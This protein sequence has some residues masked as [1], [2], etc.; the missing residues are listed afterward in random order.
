[1]HPFLARVRRWIVTLA[2]HAAAL[3]RRIRSHVVLGLAVGLLSPA[4]GAQPRP[5]A[6]PNV[7]SNPSAV[8][9][10]PLTGEP[11][12]LKTFTDP[13]FGTKL[14]RIA[15]NPGTSTSPVSGTWGS[16]TRHH[17]SKDQPWSADGAFYCLENRA[18]GSPSP[19]ILDGHTFAPLFS[20]PSSAGLWD[21]RWHPAQ[22]HAHELINVNSSGTELSWVD[23]QTGRKTRT[24]TLPFAV[25]GFGA[26][27]GNASVDGRYVALASGTRMFVVDM[28]PLPPLAPY[29]GKRI[30]PAVDVSSCGLSGG[31]S[32]DWVSISA[33]GKYAVVNY[34]G[35]HPRVFDIDPATLT[36]SPHPRRA[37]RRAAR[38]PPPA[39]T[40]TTSAMPISPESVRQQC[41]RTD[42]TGALRQPRRDLGGKKIGYVVMVRLSD[43]AITPLTSPDNEAYPHHVSTRNIRMP[44][45]A[46]VSHYKQSGARFSDE[47]TAVKLDGSLACMRYT[48]AHSAFSGCYRCEVHPVPSPDGSMIAFASNWAQDCGTGCGSSSV[49]KDYVVVASG[50]VTDAGDAPRPAAAGL[51]LARIWPNPSS[52]PLRVTFALPEGGPASLEL[53][54]VAGRSVLAQALGAPGAGL[55]DATF[56]T[57]ASLR[58]GTYWLRLSQGGGRTA[59]RVVILE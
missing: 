56:G 47:I 32:I 20:V 42:R 54:D 25:E 39:A 41:R 27:E 5:E 28:N 43:G 24:W 16:D 55:H 8:Y 33:S 13:T 46:F 1:M 34:N 15:S 2:H 30:G 37:G 35:D 29:P 3:L 51:A 58:P 38:A 6:A 7:L 48:H 14:L 44:G 22:A 45:W 36:L 4:A 31:C 19:L 11:A 17:Y 52:L 9:S 21:Y 10:V 53:V 50:A 59:S 12:Y 40:S 57:A 26:G 49:I 18:G 23:A